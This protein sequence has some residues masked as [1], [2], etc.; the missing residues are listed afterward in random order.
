[1]EGTL[2]KI[3]EIPDPATRPTIP[4][5]EAFALLGYSPPVGYEQIRLGNFPVPV[6]RLGRSIRVP[7]A[8]LLRLLGLLDGG[9]PGEN[10]E[11]TPGRSA[12]QD[13]APRP[14]A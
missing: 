12:G 8:P 14:T 1:L 7:T 2:A 3:K 4:A 6:L 11:R 9:E 5:A 13:P 10:A